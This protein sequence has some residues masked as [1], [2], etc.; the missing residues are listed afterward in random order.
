MIAHIKEQSVLLYQNS[1]I[2]IHKL[3][4]ILEKEPFLDMREI[5][6][7]MVFSI[8][9]VKIIG[10]NLISWREITNTFTN[11]SQVRK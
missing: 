10:E 9:S 2:E 11:L 3:R 6:T 8:S 1:R 5:K 4:F 7:R